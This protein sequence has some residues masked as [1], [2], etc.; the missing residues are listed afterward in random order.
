MFLMGDSMLSETRHCGRNMS[1]VTGG[2]RCDVCGKTLI[3]H[4]DKIK[5][6][7]EGRKNVQDSF[8]ERDK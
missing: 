8:D 1:Y 3:F 7:S 2:L 5:N 4:R 6:H